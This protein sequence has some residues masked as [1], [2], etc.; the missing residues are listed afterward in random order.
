MAGASKPA[1]PGTYVI[2]VLFSVRPESRD[3]FRAAVLENAKLSLEREPGCEVFDVCESSATGD[4]FLYEAYGTE[5][6]FKAH[7]FT[8][9]FKHFDKLCASWVTGKQVTSYA[10]LA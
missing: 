2:T 4:F 9:H 5:D 7:L 10:R 1:S 6:D 3:A 8:E